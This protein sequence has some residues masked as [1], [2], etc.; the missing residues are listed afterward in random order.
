MMVCYG[1]ELKCVLL[2]VIGREDLIEY[3]QGTVTISR[4]KN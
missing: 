3:N 4:G 2:C 1:L